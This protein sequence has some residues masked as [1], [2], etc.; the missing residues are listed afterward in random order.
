MHS[1]LQPNR[2]Y[3]AILH[4]LFSACLCFS[5]KSMKMVNLPQFRFNDIFFQFLF[6]DNILLL[7]II[8]WT[9]LVVWWL[10]IVL[11]IQGIQV[12][13]LIGELWSHILWNNKAEHQNCWACV[14]GAHV[15]QLERLH[16]TATETLALGP[17]HSNYWAVASQLNSLC[18][19][20]KTPP[21]PTKIPHAATNTW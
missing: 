10:R 8:R 2:L 12:P 19:Q 14:S 21:D 7:I 9:F 15:P 13:S 20:K 16:T 18:T 4:A 1:I 17:K 5:P 3:I 6:F 11:A